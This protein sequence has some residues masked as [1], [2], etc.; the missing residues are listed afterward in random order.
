MFRKY[1][2]Y[3]NVVSSLALV[4]ALSGASY[5]AVVLPRNSV[6]T[7]QLKNGAVTSAKVKDGSLRAKDLKAGEIPGIPG[8]ERIEAVA[9]ISPGDAF[10][11]KSASC[12]AGKR[13]LGGGYALQ[14]SKFHV[15]YAYSQSNEVYAVTAVLIPGQTVTTSSQLIVVAICA[16]VD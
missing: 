10:V 4:I 8:Y 13:L 3:A 9:D 1:L 11:I 2:S 12:P 14:E 16:S 7:P 5:A 6:D 15:T